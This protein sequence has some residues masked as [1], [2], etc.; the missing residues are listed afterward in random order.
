MSRSKS[1]SASPE[2]SRKMRT[3]SNKDGRCQEISTI[4]VASGVVV[5]VAVGAYP[6]T[7]VAHLLLFTGTPGRNGGRSHQIRF[8]DT[9]PAG[10]RRANNMIPVS[11]RALRIRM[12]IEIHS[13]DEC[14]K[15]PARFRK[16]GQTCVSR[17]AGMDPTMIQAMDRRCTAQMHMLG[18]TRVQVGGDGN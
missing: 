13:G 12:P 16:S 5:A 17:M 9:H 7:R 8:S 14:W 15:G 1:E 2:R 18:L 11:V 6:K 4:R 10:M 3:L